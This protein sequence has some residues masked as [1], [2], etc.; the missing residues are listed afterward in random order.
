VIQVVLRSPRGLVCERALG[1]VDGVVE[2]AVVRVRGD[3]RDLVPPLGRGASGVVSAEAPE[4]VH[5]LGVLK[6]G[7]QPA[8]AEGRE[9]GRAAHVLFEM[10]G[11]PLVD[12][13]R[14]AIRLLA[15]QRAEQAFSAGHGTG[16]DTPPVANTPDGADR[17]G[18]YGKRLR[19]SIAH[20]EHGRPL[21]RQAS[22][23]GEQLVGYRE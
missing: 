19:S 17:G 18:I 16:H 14:Q 5:V 1:S 4:L 6:L 3:D 13:G 21:P 12:G 22:P 8:T 15:M 2:A 11:L 7:V 23:E 9:R 20:R 10:V